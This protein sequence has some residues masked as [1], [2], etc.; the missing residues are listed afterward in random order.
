MAKTAGA[1]RRQRG[2]I[3][4]LPS[5][6]LRVRVYAGVDPVTGKKHHLT[7]IIPAG[8]RA[9]K[10]AEK[11]RTRL[12]AQVDE[13]RNPRTRATVNQ[14]L[15][16]HLEMLNV[17]ATTLDS[18]EVFVRNHI[19]PL[20]GHLQVGRIDGEILDSFYRQLRTCRAHCRGKAFIEHRTDREHKC[21]QR[22]RPHVCRPLAAGSLLKIHAILNGAG[23]RAVRWG[24]IG[25]NPFELAES[26][27]VPH[28][29]PR[30]PT[31]AQAA[32][33]AEEAWRDL[34]WGMLV[35]VAMTTGARR[36][37]LCALR[38]DRVDFNTGVLHI[39]SSVGQRG[40]RTWEK[41]TKT[42]QQRRITLDT[43]TV[44]LLAAYQ[45]HCV[46]R[47]G[48]GATMPGDARIFSPMPDGSMWIKPDT[49]SQRYERM[50]ARLGWDMH[51]HQLRHYS[52]TELIAAGVDVRT[53]AGRLGHGGGGTT[54]LKVYS[55][56]VAEAD[57]RAAGS[58]SARMPPL[59]AR[60]AAVDGTVVPT[61]GTVVPTVVPAP[62]D[63]PSSPYQRIADDLRGAITSGVLSPG[64]SLPT[65]DEL[66]QRYGVSHGTAQRAVSLLRTSGLVSVSRGRR[67]IV[68]EAQGAEDA[69]VLPMTARKGGRSH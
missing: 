37:E 7:E 39:R 3:E 59:P 5:G 36:G 42:H 26:I 57:Q 38:W 61:V 27:S 41:D 58:L 51:I 1:G 68:R 4:M 19:R 67:A 53:V 13:R 2:E 10:L 28:S 17:E 45:L 35:W 62:A 15:D 46:E 14:M 23:K 20:I 21:D 25:R 8:P 54:T 49:V 12:L 52:A 48:F 33:I 30:P 44:A 55:A 32:A 24:W 31:A 64:Q 63:E 34:D 40:A 29:D 18:Y 22:C 65:I 43:Q 50:C 60:L 16:R 9:D 56:F 69:T 6:S 11:A 66:A 47:A